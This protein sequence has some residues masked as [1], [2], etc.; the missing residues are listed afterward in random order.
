M[1]EQEVMAYFAKNYPGKNLVRLP[2]QNPTEIICE[3]EPSADHPEWNLAIAAILQSEPHYHDHAVEVYEVLRGELELTVDDDTVHLSKGDTFT[4]FPPQ[5]HFAKG[6]FTLVKVRS[7]PGWTA[8]DHVL[9]G[10]R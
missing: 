8:D 3:V 4:V 6:D 1:T 9:K 10:K 7:E 2:Q 5:V